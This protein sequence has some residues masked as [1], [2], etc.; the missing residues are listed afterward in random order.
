[1]ATLIDFTTFTDDKITNTFSKIQ[2]RYLDPFT[3]VITVKGN[4]RL[5][6]EEINRMIAT[7]YGDNRI[8]KGLDISK[9]DTSNEDYI[10]IYLNKGT[11][12]VDSTIIEFTDDIILRVPS[13]WIDRTNTEDNVIFIDYNHITTYPPRIAYII[14]TKVS[15]TRGYNPKIAI[16]KYKIDGSNITYQN[17]IDGKFINGDEIKIG[18]T[19]FKIE[20][21]PGNLSDIYKKLSTIDFSSLSS[22]GGYVNYDEVGYLILLNTMPFNQ[23]YYDV[24]N[25]SGTINVVEGSAIY[26]SA[27]KCYDIKVDESSKLAIIETPE[28]INDSNTYYRFYV[29][30]D[31]TNTPKIEYSIDGGTTY[32][33]IDPNKI[34]LVESGFNKLKLKF[35]FDKDSKF[36]SYG[37]LYDYEFTG[38]T[39]DTRMFEVYQVPNDMT[40]PVDIILPNGATYTTDGKSLEVYLNGKRLVNNI[41]FEEV[42]SHTVR[43][44][45]NLNKG[46]VIV[47]TEKYG[48]V[49]TSIENKHKLDS[50]VPSWTDN[51]ANYIVIRDKTTG[52]L[53]KLYIDNGALSYEKIE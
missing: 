51:V 32:K 1:M 34:I 35:T 49:D 10:D 31:A 18:D 13:T 38:Y 19:T 28:I 14:T 41:D 26:N 11:C 24:F 48:Y 50:L 23:I 4:S 47:F 2:K 33:E 45:I 8:I 3:N 9:I 29:F 20:T 46:D 52:D 40:A 30:V 22:S 43:F 36:Y 39:T 17:P 15:D 27:S 37:V 6:D 21:P 12:I 44:N 53:Y 25:E 16:G 42:D 7:I 5:I